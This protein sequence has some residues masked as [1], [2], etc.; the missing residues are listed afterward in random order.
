[1]A[2]HEGNSVERSRIS[3]SEDNDAREELLRQVESIDRRDPWAW[4]T[5]ASSM[6]R[7]HGHNGV[8][9]IL[10]YLQENNLVEILTD[11]ES[12]Y[13]CDKILAAAL[14]EESRLQQLSDV[15]H[16][17]LS[18][19]AFAWPDFYFRILYSHLGSE[20]FERAF[21]W[22]LKL[23]PSFSPPSSVFGALLS[24][25][26][27]D[28]TPA[29]QDTLTALYSLSSERSLYDHIVPSLFKTGNSGL[30]R[31]W[32]KLLVSLGDYPSS[33]ESA[34]F[35][36]FL[37]N[38]YPLIKLSETELH[39]VKSK[40]STRIKW[41]VATLQSSPVHEN[42]K[43]SHFSDNI[44]A[45]WFASSWTPVEFAVNFVQRL[46]LR[47]IGPRSL[48][49]LA[50]REQTAKDT[51]KRITQLRKLGVEIDSQTYSRVLVYLAD[52]GRDYILNDFL[53]CDIHPDEFENEET[54]QRLVAAANRAGDM[55][56][57]D[58]LEH[59]EQAIQSFSSP[60][61][62]RA[63]LM[64]KLSKK[65]DHN[66]GNLLQ[67]M[68]HANIQPTQEEAMHML[69]LS[70]QN[71][72]RNGV[73][74]ITPS[75]KDAADD[76]AETI[77]LITRLTARGVAVPAF[78]WRLLMTILARNDDWQ[79]LAMVCSKLPLLYTT[80]TK[81][82]M[83]IHVQDLPTTQDLWVGKAGNVLDGLYEESTHK[84]EWLKMPW[85]LV[86]DEMA[87]IP[88]DL[89]LT[90]RQHPLSKVFDPKMQRAMIRWGFNSSMPQPPQRPIN[91]DSVRG[92]A[93]AE[94]DIARGVRLLG[95]LRHRGVLIDKQV[96]VSTVLHL[97]ALSQIPG[98]PRH[99]NRD[100][101]E[102]SPANIKAWVDV[103]WG[104]EIMPNEEAIEEEIERR[105]PQ[106]VGRY[107]KLLR[108]QM[109]QNLESLE[110]DN[111]AALQEDA[112]YTK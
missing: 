63:V 68:S 91:A 58:L 12:A 14:E 13:L 43:S 42:F 67:R 61:M 64:S 21:K 83:A 10:E 39:L 38:Y 107:R 16:G 87:Y 37:N 73:L 44:V 104:E 97:M 4:E 9:Q 101:L 102:M 60:R 5:I 49:A 34:E 88:A 112:L 20:S 6:S 57:A 40:K 25:F 2:D 103:A 78:C 17:L 33:A 31:N 96:I 111:I 71:I 82:L 95:I 86:H 98:R 47:V 65:P 23:K 35:L 36:R 70:F 94:Y 24:S 81:P 41:D 52:S 54:R 15:A 30:A 29:M 92:K 19:F 105:M 55:R 89:P 62:N 48:Q 109:S 106:L 32:R 11:E 27:T 85:A 3:V 99:R 56:T 77:K 76:I 84:S 79:H 53:S 90:H 45:R 18:N 50:I 28:A 108:R 69:Y 7:L 75:S 22:H 66:V 93:T 80:S 1:M 72:P 110:D 26:V 51:S 46:G 100:S 8:W 74:N 59:V